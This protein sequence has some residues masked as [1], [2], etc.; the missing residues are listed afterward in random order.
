MNVFLALFHKGSIGTHSDD[1]GG[2]RSLLGVEW[3]MQV[4]VKL[5]YILNN[6]ISNFFI[7]FRV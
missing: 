1:I 7:V 6:V 4:L 5:L 2:K 3:I